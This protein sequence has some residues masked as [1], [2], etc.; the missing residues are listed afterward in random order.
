MRKTYN[1]NEITKHLKNIFESGELV[2]KEVS[3][4]LEHTTRSYGG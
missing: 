1:P 3:S 2:E 4:I